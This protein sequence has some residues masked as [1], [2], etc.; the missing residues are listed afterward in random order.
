ML[1]KRRC[2]KCTFP[3]IPIPKSFFKEVFSRN[4][5]LFLYFLAENGIEFKKRT[6]KEGQM[7]GLEQA[8]DLVD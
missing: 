3:I 5:P 6:E 1:L 8:M 7:M 2:A 4:Y